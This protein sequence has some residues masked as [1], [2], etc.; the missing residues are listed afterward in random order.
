[1]YPKGSEWKKWDLHLHTPLTKSSDNYHSSSDRLV[2]DEFCEII[3]NSDVEAIGI[4]DYFSFDGYFTFIDK[5]RAKYPNSKKV[6]FPNVELRLNESVNSVQEEVNVHLI[7]RS[8]ITKQEAAKFLSCLKTLKTDGNGR[9]ISCDQLVKGPSRNDF[10]GATVTRKSVTNAIKEVFGEKIVRQDYVLILAAVNNDGARPERGKQRKEIITDEIDKFCDAFFGGS[11]NTDH[12]LKTDRL[13]DKELKIKEKP[14]LSGCDAHSFDDL[15]AW[16]GKVLRN[17][18]TNKETTWIKADLTYEGLLQI[19]IEP[20]ERV[21]IGATRPD[22]KETYKVID[23]VVFTGTTDFP[24]EIQFNDN[25]CSIIGSR[26]SGKSA[27]LNYIAHAIDKPG[28]ESQLRGPAAKISWQGL[29]MG[30]TVYWAD[31]SKDG[32][33]KVVFLHQGYL[34]GI[35]DKPE[36][37]T[38]KIKPV[39]FRK[40]TVIEAE[41]KATLNTIASSNKAI[42]LSIQRWFSAKGSINT[43]LG[44]IKTVGEKTAITAAKDEYQKKIDE[45]KT[46]LSL[47]DQEIKDYQKISADVV[48]YEEQIKAF[49]SLKDNLLA[50]YFDPISKQVIDLSLDFT[51]NP[52]LDNLPQELKTQI[53]DWVTKSGDK[54]VQEANASILAY[55][56]Q[57]A[58]KV[59]TATNAIVKLKKDNEDLIDKN[60]KNEQLAKL[61]EELNKQESKLTLIKGK[62]DEIKTLQGK[63]ETEMTSISSNLH[64]REKALADLKT[65]FTNLDQTENTIEF[66]IESFF[67]DQSIIHLSERYNLREVKDNEFIKDGFID[68]AKTRTQYQKLLN[69]LSSDRIALKNHEDPQAVAIQTLTFSEDIRFTA[70]MEGDSIGGFSE[71]SMTPGKQALFALTLILDESYDAWPLLIDQPEDDL[72]SRS[73]YDQI[74]TYFKDKKKERQIIMVSHNANL[75]VGADSEQIIVAN[76]HGDDRKNKD[77]RMFNYITGSLEDTHPR[78]RSNHLV[79]ESCGIREHACDI[80]DG[81]EEAFAKRKNK[82]KL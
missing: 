14:V 30:C 37:I 65:S 78:D 76:K 28:I 62:E 22:E 47:T 43:L 11:Q 70:L 19:L 42:E 45:I 82:Y 68:V 56:N 20:K 23:R 54:I 38:E 60:K 6:I 50:E 26:S 39:L 21:N 27:L 12:F 44:E 66:G 72:D 31:G 77:G 48:M 73:I 25:L 40:F 5:F 57:L 34:S 49:T 79:L 16:L 7:F 33:G 55:K 3:E 4:T 81:G 71:S 75:V 61:I 17:D 63:A 80:L 51:F 15:R 52:S 13:E 32:S 64:S 35:S 18:S 1:M 74:A 8:E 67:S 58:T 9:E 24:A 10:E 2:W 36:E 59:K 41:Y 53:E 46:S 69:D 29:T